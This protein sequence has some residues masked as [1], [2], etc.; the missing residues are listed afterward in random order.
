MI[1]P[2]LEMAISAPASVDPKVL[3]VLSVV[4]KDLKS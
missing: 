4:L 1:A 2:P 3:V